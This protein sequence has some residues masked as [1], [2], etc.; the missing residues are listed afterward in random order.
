LKHFYFFADQTNT[1]GA[2]SLINAMLR[3]ECGINDAT[4]SSSFIHFMETWWSGNF[5]L[6][7]Y[8]VI[9][10]LA[11]LTLTPFIQT[12]SDSKC[13]EKSKLLREAI[14]KFDIT[15]VKRYE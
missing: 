15:I 13:N 5:I 3:E 2:Q 8:D 14:M 7:K 4:Y 10:K 1:T 12:I 9:A 6:T 11:E